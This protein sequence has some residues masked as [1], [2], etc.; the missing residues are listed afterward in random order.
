MMYLLK[1]NKQTKLKMVAYGIG[2]TG[3]AWHLLGGHARYLLV[4]LVS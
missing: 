2:S 1:G 3:V 4:S